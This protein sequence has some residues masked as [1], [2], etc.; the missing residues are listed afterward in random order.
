MPEPIIFGEGCVIICNASQA[1]FVFENEILFVDVGQKK[2]IGDAH[3]DLLGQEI[4]N[5]DPRLLARLVFEHPDAASVLIEKLER[6]I[7]AF[8]EAER[9]LLQ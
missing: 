7:D 2:C 1:G 8:D 3:M 6:V 5:D 9:D 4:K